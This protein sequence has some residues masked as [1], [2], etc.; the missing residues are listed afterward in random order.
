[1]CF[2]E[3]TKMSYFDQRGGT[4]MMTMLLHSAKRKLCIPKES[5]QLSYSD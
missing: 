4:K 3:L 2:L 1:M 5:I